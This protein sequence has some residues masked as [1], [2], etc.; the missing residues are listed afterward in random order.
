[1]SLILDA[2]NKADRERQAP[3]EAPK[4]QSVHQPYSPPTEGAQWRHY[5]PH[6]LG[7]MSVLLLILVIYLLIGSK[8]PDL[9]ALTQPTVSIPKAVDE[10]KKVKTEQPQEAPKPVQ[11]TPAVPMEPASQLVEEKKAAHTPQET[12]YSSAVSSL[13]DRPQPQ[14]TA[15]TKPAP[16]KYSQPKQPVIS[17]KQI[18]K[19]MYDGAVP[20][21]KLPWSIQEKIPTLMYS[22]H[23]YRPDGTDSSSTV[24]LNNGVWSKGDKIA[25]GVTIEEIREK[26]LILKYKEH[27][28]SLNALSSWVNM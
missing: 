6:I 17:Q 9:P 20:I 24:T 21:R 2:L 1:M 27:T 4:L 3:T 16:K 25:P 14:Q 23:Q 5:I 19:V 11:S 13:Y 8:K 18:D 7:G 28:F 12:N 26:V 15:P 22:D 10:V